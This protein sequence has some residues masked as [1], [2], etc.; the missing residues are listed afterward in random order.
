VAEGVPLLGC[1]LHSLHN[2]SRPHTISVR[3]DQE[4]FVSA[5]TNDGIGA[6][7]TLPQEGCDLCQNKVADK[8]AKNLNLFASGI[9]LVSACLED[10][11]R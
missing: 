7:D 3:Q 1:S 4:E 2:G 9:R 10:E 6:A 5:I 8:V 11:A